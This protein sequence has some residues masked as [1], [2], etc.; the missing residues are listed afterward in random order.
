MR[1]PTF[2]PTRMS[3]ASTVPEPCSV[4]S[5]WNQVAK[6]AV[7]ASAAT[8]RIMKTHVLRFMASVST[9]GCRSIRGSHRV[10]A[11]RQARPQ[12]VECGFDAFVQR[13]VSVQRPHQQGSEDRLA[14]HVGDFRRRQVTADFA[15]LLTDA[16]DLAVQ[17]VNAFL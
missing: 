10:S 13:G 15:A 2:E 9:R 12:H 8:I 4:V 6:T 5:L 14:K 16:D 17:R 7:A 1:P 11:R 3:R